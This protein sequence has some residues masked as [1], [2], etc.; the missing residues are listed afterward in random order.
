MRGPPAKRTVAAMNMAVTIDITCSAVTKTSTFG[1][2][3]PGQKSQYVR[4]PVQSVLGL[5]DV[6]ARQDGLNL[7]EIG[8]AILVDKIRPRNQKSKVD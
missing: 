5:I 1:E 3:I 8:S 7:I 6:M 4:Y 2:N